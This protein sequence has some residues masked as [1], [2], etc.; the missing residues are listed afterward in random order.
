MFQ[1]T[2]R[3]LIHI[4]M[5]ASQ[6]ASIAAALA[7]IAGCVTLI[8]TEPEPPPP[9]EA[10][11]LW[12][13]RLT[14]E[15]T[16]SSQQ[17][18]EKWLM[19]AMQESERTS[20]PFNDLDSFLR[21]FPA[22]PN[23]PLYAFTRQSPESVAEMSEWLAIYTNNGANELEGY[24][25]FRDFLEKFVNAVHDFQEQ[26]FDY[27][28]VSGA[29][30]RNASDLNKMEIPP[31]RPAAEHHPFLLDSDFV[32][33]EILA[34]FLRDVGSE[35]QIRLRDLKR[36]VPL[37]TSVDIVRFAAEGDFIEME[38]E[39]LPDKSNKRAQRAFLELLQFVV[40]EFKAI[41]AQRLN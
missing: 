15:N 32:R 29:Y 11:A 1:N 26:N 35:F 13:D 34:R 6:Y 20:L 2:T 5:K 16:A 14:G 17:Q 4:A 27:R 33:W 37:K 19:N 38:V 22:P 7:I 8:S 9:D 12:A 28:E 21:E 36:N 3:Q 41:E 31:R 18:V 40:D 30:A 39:L 24:I 25:Q 10:L 23:A